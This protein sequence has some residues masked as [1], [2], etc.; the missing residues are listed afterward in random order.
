[1]EL[2][3][4][5]PLHKYITDIKNNT[6]MVLCEIRTALKKLG[7][8]FPKIIDSK[9]IKSSKEDNE[10][11]SFYEWII[12]REYLNQLEHLHEVVE[13]I[14]QNIDSSPANIENHLKTMSG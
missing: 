11:N 12:F 13:V 3:K 10:N 9:N 4:Y 2:E 1:M 8:P 7:A 5:W 14:I 6:K